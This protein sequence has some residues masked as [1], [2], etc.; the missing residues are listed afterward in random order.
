M[1]IE[2]D[3][4]LHNNI[5]KSK[6]TFDLLRGISK[7]NNGSEP[8]KYTWT[9]VP[10]THI[11]TSYLREAATLLYDIPDLIPTTANKVLLYVAIFCG[12]STRGTTTQLTIYTQIKDKVYGYCY[13]GSARGQL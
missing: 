12:K 11:G 13:L 10:L 9:S 2:P 5:N 6:T 8:S 4:N 1:R 3:S 7:A